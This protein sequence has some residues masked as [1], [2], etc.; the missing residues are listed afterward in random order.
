MA[1]ASAQRE[2]LV[3]EYTL[4]S[5]LAEEM[6]KRI[7]LLNASMN[8]VAAARRALEETQNLNEGDELLVPLG[9]GVFVRARLANKSSVVVTIGASIMIEK[10]VDE[11]LRIIGSREQRIRDALQRSMAE[12]QALLNRLQELEQQIRSMNR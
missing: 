1:E 7:E 11:A 6:R 4:V 12:Y 2:Q 10:N 9:A 5:Q 3:A 8:E